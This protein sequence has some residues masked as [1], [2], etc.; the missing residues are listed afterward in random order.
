MASVEENWLECI[1]I[2]TIIMIVCRVLSSTQEESIK[3][4]GYLL[5]RRI[6][7]ATF[8]LLGQLSRKMQASKDEKASRD[9]QG[10]LRDMAATCRSTFDVDGDPSLLLTSNDDIK[11]FAYCAV[12]IYDNTPSQLGNLPQHSK[13][14]LE[15][16]KR[17]CHA[18]E[19]AVRQ[20]A[21]IHR[22]GLDCAVAEIWDNYRQG[23]P[24]KALPAPNS[25]W[26]VT[27]TAPSDSQSPQ[28]VHYN[29]I[30]GCLLVD[31]K[32]LGRLPS[33]IV[34][35]PTYQAIFGDVSF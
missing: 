17:C 34:Q 24:W 3:S 5:L 16:D 11:I 25:R 8:T 13:L 19:A 12:M 22:E 28:A 1:T 7:T 6:R 20:Y 29:L 27:Q 15:R 26:L 14:L 32:P 21:E 4:M 23:T 30:N 35:H 9:L 10:R 18:L 31:G 33:I 2:N